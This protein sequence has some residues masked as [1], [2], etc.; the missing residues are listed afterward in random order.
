MCTVLLPGGGY[1]IAGKYI[2]S[3]ENLVQYFHKWTKDRTTEETG[4]S[5]QTE[6]LVIEI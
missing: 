6:S 2:I 3:Y 4:C 1:P 5:I